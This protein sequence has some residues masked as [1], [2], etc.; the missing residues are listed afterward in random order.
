VNQV[1]GGHFPTVVVQVAAVIGIFF[2]QAG[3]I[4][5]FYAGYVKHHPARVMP[6]HQLIK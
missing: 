4:A 3:P 6:L 5:R 1:F 2:E